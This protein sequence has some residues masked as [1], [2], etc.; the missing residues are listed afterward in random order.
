MTDHYAT[1]ADAHGT[2]DA[3]SEA[4]TR[5][6]WVVGLLAAFA[7]TT[8]AS[9]V[10]YGLLHA[11]NLVSLFW[12]S[13]GVLTVLFL[14]ARGRDR[15]LSAVVAAVV[16]F[17]LEHYIAGYTLAEASVATAWNVSETALVA[18]TSRLVLGCDIDFS[19]L[20][21]LL[22]FAT[23]CVAP[24][25]ALT[26]SIYSWVWPTPGL[27]SYGVMWPRLFCEEYLG[28]AMV[29]PA[30]HAIA[31]P[32]DVHLFA[33][34]RLERAGLLILLLAGE[35]ILFGF[36]S[37]PALFVVF[38]VLIGIGFR[39]GPAGAAQAVIITS[40]V[41]FV[42]ALLNVGA[43]ATFSENRFGAAALVQIFVLAVIYSVL[44]T[45]GAVADS[46]RTRNELQRVQQELVA[47]SRRAGRAEVAAN[48]LHNV[49]NALNS[50]N[51]CANLL[52]QDVKAS[53]VDGLRRLVELFEHQDLTAFAVTTR[54]KHLPE[55][56]NALAQ[57]LTDEQHR[58]VCELT[59]LTDHVESITQIVATQQS[60]ARTP[61]DRVAGTANLAAA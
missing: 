55:F 61:V 4:R 40:L 39:L 2:A 31:V 29:A 1:R 22:R 43:L 24:V 56:L 5:R 11:V 10:P 7:L 41:A 9:C 19:R 20:G 16:N 18:A 14:V 30:L 3:D 8:F 12:P 26:V 42:Y 37:T 27:A 36:S 28:I 51:V 33:R 32:R 13:N 17:I 25:V 48:V 52:I 49:G 58:A 45:A 46:L 35:I 34:S 53:R 50:V 47:A 38:P 23:L 6:R 57:K 59:S 54:G 21:T 60:H 15:W 44:P